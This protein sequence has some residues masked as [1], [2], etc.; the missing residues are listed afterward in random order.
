M[1]PVSAITESNAPN[2]KFPLACTYRANCEHLRP[3]HSP[4]TSRNHR[5]A[6]RARS[7]P[8][9]CSSVCAV[10]RETS[11]GVSL[12]FCCDNESRQPQTKGHSAAFFLLVHNVSPAGHG[13]VVKVTFQLW[14]S[15][16]FHEMRVEATRM[17]TVRHTLLSLIIIN[18]STP[19]HLDRCP[20]GD[21]QLFLSSTTPFNP[22]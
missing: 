12:K 18:H 4:Q 6:A 22:F 2:V 16:Y 15:S 1:P 7:Q 9:T 21:D 3:L 11:P 20:L 13:L 14:L 19:M 10:L 17:P 8:P 5:R